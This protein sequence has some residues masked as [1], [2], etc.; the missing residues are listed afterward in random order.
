MKRK[1]IPE[2]KRTKSQSRLPCLSSV[3]LNESEKAII[4]ITLQAM[5]HE[6]R[7][8]LMVI[9][10]FSRKLVDTLDASSVSSQY[11]R[12]LLREALRLE[13][14]LSLMIDKNGHRNE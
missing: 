12:I 1:S 8:P 11:A 2:V 5:A 9:G 6:I 4:D 14:L 10:A 13:T 3:T 7:N